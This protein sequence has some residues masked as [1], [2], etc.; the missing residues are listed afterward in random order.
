[1][2]YMRC[3]CCMCCGRKVFDERALCHNMLLRK[4]LEKRRLSG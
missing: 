4:K 1:M 3:M 2:Q